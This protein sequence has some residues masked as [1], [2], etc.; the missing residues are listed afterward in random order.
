MCVFVGSC[1]SVHRRWAQGGRGEARLCDCNELGAGEV[2][3]TKSHSHRVGE[4]APH[5]FCGMSGVQSEGAAFLPSLFPSAT[6]PTTK[7]AAV[8]AKASDCTY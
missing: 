7:Q 3:E 4:G 8:V 6:F 2:R 5:Y 1:V